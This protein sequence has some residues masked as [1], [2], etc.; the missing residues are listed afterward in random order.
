MG[1]KN[2]DE[3]NK[4][5]AD[6]I[7]GVLTVRKTRCNDAPPTM[8]D[9]QVSDYCAAIS[10]GILNGKPSYLYLDADSSLESLE[11]IFL[12]LS[13]AKASSDLEKRKIQLYGFEKHDQGGDDQNKVYRTIA[14]CSNQLQ[15][16]HEMLNDII[17]DEISARSENSF[18]KYLLDLQLAAQSFHSRVANTFHKA[19]LHLPRNISKRNHKWQQF[20]N[21]Q[22]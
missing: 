17:H 14:D 11:V 10:N 12:S 3:Y 5:V 19:A 2:K 8:R 6:I 7:L 15:S 20:T 1:L 18:D 21:A 9:I 4:T 22:G 13:S 16:V